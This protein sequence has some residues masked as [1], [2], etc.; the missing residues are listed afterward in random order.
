MSQKLPSKRSR[1]LTLLMGWFL[2]IALLPLAFV[3]LRVY[4]TFDQAMRRT[5]QNNLKALADTKAEHIEAYARERINDLHILANSPA[6]ANLLL[7]LQ[8]SARQHGYSSPFYLQSLAVSTPTLVG[9]A[10]G[11]GYQNVYLFDPSGTKLFGI[12]EMGDELGKNYMQGELARTP[13]GQ[14]LIH[15]L[16][17]RETEISDFEL[18]PGANSGEAIAYLA[19]PVVDSKTNQ[20]VGAVALQMTNEALARIVR[21]ETGLGRTGETVVLARQGDHLVFVSPTR[22]HPNAGFR[23]SIPIQGISPN[24]LDAVSNRPGQGECKDYYGRK[25]LAAW[26]YIEPLR[27]GMMVKLDTEEAFA[28][29]RDQRNLVLMLAGITLVLVVSTSLLLA[30]SISRPIVELTQVARQVSAGDLQQKVRVS[31]RDEIGELAEAFNKMTADLRSFYATLDEKVRLRTLELEERNAELAR[32]KAEAE[33]ANKAKSQFLANMSHEI[34]T[35][36]NAVIGMSG[37]LLETPLN[38]EQREF[39]HVIRTSGDALLTLLNDML[40]FSK[41]EAGQLELERHPFDLR[42]CLESS[43]EML[44]VR[45]SEKHLDLACLIEPDVPNRIV[46]DVTRLRQIL[47]NLVG[48]AVKFTQTGEVIVRVKRESFVSETCQAPPNAVTI[49][50]AV[51]DTGIGIPAERMDRLFKPFSQV[52]AST[53]RQYGGTGLGL[54]ISKRLCSMMNGNMWVESEVGRGSTFHFTIV[55]TIAGPSSKPDLML[56]LH[57]EGKRILIVD[58]N[59]TNRLIL[60]RQALSWRMEPVE[61]ANATE[62]LQL[63]EQ[64]Q[65]FDL[66][67]LDMIMPDMDGIT[68]AQAIRQH[69][70][71]SDLPLVA[72]SSVGRRD[73]LAEGVQFAAFL[74]K[75]IKQSQLYEVLLSV[76]TAGQTSSLIV[77]SES[78]FD[79]RL[80]EI[81]PLRILLAEDTVVNQKLML[82]MLA[83]M[84]YQADLAANG[85]EV[86]A[87][88]ERQPYDLVLMDVQMPVMDGLEAA[89]RIRAQFPPHLQPRIVA[90]TANAMK[91]DRQACQSA[92]MDDYLSKPIQVPELQAAILRAES[93]LHARPDRTSPTPSSLDLTGLRALRDGGE[94]NIIRE[95]FD[96]FRSEAPTLLQQMRQATQGGDINALRRAAHSL[97]GAAASLGAKSL[98]GL[99]AKIERRARTGVIEGI[100]ELIGEAEVHTHAVLKTLAG[101]SVWGESVP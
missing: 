56:P 84:G 92:G 26:R 6:V 97:K 19:A 95:V 66:A 74:T 17:Q 70:P 40:D 101:E 99:C 90:L 68:L 8:E 32:A 39:V 44:S 20:L 24:W 80:G 87:A 31:R 16:I 42:E 41:I 28:D 93:R 63:I 55:A 98:A 76:F 10:R 11:A 15:A 79:P 27:W 71:P 52:D 96:V 43:L 50:F 60:S 73:A 58:D 64:G 34:R 45:A 25:V 23:E 65:R 21:D 48:N 89:R 82:R 51:Q 13:I 81:H 78:M 38:A 54:A 14:T 1:I 18:P 69:R 57:L 47:V 46:G 35:P 94:P 53:T 4:F 83:R 61:A 49:H 59:A 3:L 7:V 67:I 91:E 30:R 75:P 36:M 62:A 85:T 5:V 33:G 88:L 86:L 37:L 22:H 100:V 2:L 9:Y 77:P 72:L 12:G 29:I